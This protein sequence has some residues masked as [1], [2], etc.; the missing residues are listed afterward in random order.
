[1]KDQ[2]LRRILGILALVVA[3]LLGVR[4]WRGMGHDVSLVYDAPPGDLEVTLLD[5]DAHPLRHV[6]FA[7][8]AERRHTARLPDGPLTARIEVAGRTIDRDFQIGN[9]DTVEIH[10]R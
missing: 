6:Y 8:G 1:V 9:A 10:A 7:A 5:H 3:V 4:A 2:R